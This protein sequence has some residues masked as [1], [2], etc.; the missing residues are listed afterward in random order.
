ML[1]NLKYDKSRRS[2]LFENQAKLLLRKEKQNNFIFLTRNFFS[3]E[4]ILLKYRIKINNFDN[5]KIELLKKNFSSIDLIELKL[6]SSENR[7]LKDIILFEVKTKLFNIKYNPELCFSSF[8][9]YHEAKELGIEV[10]LVSFVL[11]EEWR[12]SFNIYEL[13]LKKMSIYSR[14]MKNRSEARERAKEIGL[15]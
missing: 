6:E 4:E 7:I 12:Y 15:I 1:L 10:K 14:S 13:D 3:F 8:Q 5:E 9:T 2:I 11:F